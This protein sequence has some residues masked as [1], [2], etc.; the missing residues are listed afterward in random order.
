[1]LLLELKHPSKYAAKNT[2]ILNIKQKQKTEIKLKLCWLEAATPYLKQ[3]GSISVKMRKI[4]N[5]KWETVENDNLNYYAFEKNE[6]M[7][8]TLNLVCLVVF[9]ENV[10]IDK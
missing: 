10:Y 8:K 1:M 9:T 2:E 6:L 4:E 5:K 7:S 3:I